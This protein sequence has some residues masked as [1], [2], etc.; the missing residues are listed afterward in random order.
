MKMTPIS[1]G[2][3]APIEAGPGNISSDAKQRAIAVMRGEEP[4]QQESTGNP[5][6]DKALKTIKMTTQVSPDR[7]VSI[8]SEKL[9]EEN[10]PQGTEQI[11]NSHNNEQAT[12]VEETKPLSPQ[13]AALA[14]AK[15]ALQ[16][17]RAQ[18]EK[19]KA[20]LA[21]KSSS[22]LA[23][24]VSKADLKSR[25][26]SVLTENGVT[27]DELTH[28]ILN[29]SGPNPE[30]QSLKSEIKALKDELTG[31]LIERD[32]LQEQQVLAQIRRDADLLTAQGEEYEAI[33]QAK[34]QRDVVDL[35]H[36]TWKQTGEILDVSEAAQLVENQLIEEAL[37]FAKIKKL[38]NK[39]NPETVSQEVQAPQTIQ[40]LNAK[41]MKTLTNKD[42][43]RPASDRRSRALAAFYGNLKRG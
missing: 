2:S 33:R 9:T 13:F 26:L 19:Q 16:I 17:E 28:A 23:D 14:K 4:K 36:R 6:A 29:G 8:P 34:A 38:Q 35:I 20:E 32:R 37:P 40:A 27:Y 11:A 30:I 3:G 7:E 22:D 31:Q 1:Q 12:R 10:V 43:A 5:Q 39:I 15:R 24:Y 25:P 21:Q 41:V 18:L 42:G